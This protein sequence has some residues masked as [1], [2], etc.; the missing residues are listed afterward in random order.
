M[1]W[2]LHKNPKGQGL[3]RLWID[4]PVEMGKNDT[5]PEDME[6]SSPFPIYLCISPIWLLLNVYV[7]CNKPVI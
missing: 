2:N 1:Q 4:E 7:F 3:E 5:L 6:A